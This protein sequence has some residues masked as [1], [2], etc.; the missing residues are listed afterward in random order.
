MFLNAVAD[1]AKMASRLNSDKVIWGVLEGT[2][3]GYQ[4]KKVVKRE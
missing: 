3:S 2:I 1:Y 4:R